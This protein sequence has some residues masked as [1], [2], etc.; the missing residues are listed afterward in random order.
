MPESMDSSP[1]QPL[2]A[3]EFLSKNIKTKQQNTKV[4]MLSGRGISLVE[5]KQVS[6][7]LGILVSWFLGFVVS[8]FRGFL[9]S[10]F[11]SFLVS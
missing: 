8:R 4:G 5:N 1:F 10:W 7:F 2:L 11:L 9:V 3:P 6:C